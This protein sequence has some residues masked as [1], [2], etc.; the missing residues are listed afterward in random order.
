MFGR[1]GWAEILI[2]VVL[3]L[4]LFSHNKIPSMMKNVADGLKVFK[5]ELKSDKNTSAEKPAPEK[6]ASHN[7]AAK[8]AKAKTAK[9]SSAAKSRAGASYVE[10]GSYA[11]VAAAQTARRKLTDA[12]ADLFE[13]SEFVI[14]EDASAAR[15]AFKLRI[16]F[17]TGAAAKKFHAAALEAGV[18]CK[19]IA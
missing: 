16:G 1:L 5:K 19:V 8:P 14:L 9:K 10:F 12:H 17:A 18:K 13:D 7:A 15:T 4:I 6:S 2:I 11:T 3:V